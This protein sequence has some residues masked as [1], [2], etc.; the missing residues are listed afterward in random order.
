MQIKN[1]KFDDN[2]RYWCL[3][4]TGFDNFNLLVGISG[5]GKT[6]ILKA[7]QNVCHFQRNATNN[8]GGDFSY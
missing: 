3:E 8:T 7:I 4:E 1:F 6:R 2:R 5:V